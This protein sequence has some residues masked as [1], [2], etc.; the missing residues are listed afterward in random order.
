MSLSSLIKEARGGGSLSSNHRLFVPFSGSPGPERRGKGD[1][2]GD[3][4][5]TVLVVLVV[6]LV[7]LWWRWDAGGRAGEA[8]VLMKLVSSCSR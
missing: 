5:V 3:G 4:R 1:D 6:F 8:A 2:V 7:T